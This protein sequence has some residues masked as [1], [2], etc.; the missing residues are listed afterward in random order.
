MKKL[1]WR[2]IAWFKRL[3]VIGNISVI[4]GVYRKLIDNGEKVS[5]INKVTQKTKKEFETNKTPFLEY[6]SFCKEKEIS[7]SK[8]DQDTLE[9]IEKTE[10]IL[11]PKG[12]LERELQKASVEYDEQYELVNKAGEELLSCRTEC[13]KTINAVQLLVNSIAAHPKEFD[14]TITKITIQKKTFNDTIEFGKKQK[15]A[16]ENSI[17]GSGA[18]VAAGAAVASMAPSA[19]M[20]VA[21]TFG[22]AS[23]G[24]AISALSGAAATNAALAWLGGGALSAG[25][26]G[27]AAGH[28]LLALAGPVGWGLAG[29]SVIAGVILFW[30]SR[31]KTKESIKKEIERM[32]NCTER[33]KELEAE[34]NAIKDG[35]NELNSNV[36]MSL[37]RLK[38]LSKGDYNSFSEEEQYNLGALVNNTNSLSKLLNKVVM[39]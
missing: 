31:I 14:K 19:A 39:E 35:T 2:I 18:G 13:L 20:W 8:R 33:L 32:K 1:W 3:Q 15:K 28:A 6:I 10:D 37:Q 36:A 25:G 12:A 26:A 17:K 9:T 22:T 7:L 4:H 27:M 30:R 16:L 29:T 5:L 11:D 21:T 38:Y 23:T 24:T 34:I